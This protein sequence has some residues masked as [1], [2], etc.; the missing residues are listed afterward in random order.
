MRSTVVFLSVLFGTFWTWSQQI[1][2]L[3]EA[4]HDM[5][6]P[7]SIVSMSTNDG[8]PQNQISSLISDDLDN[9]II[10]TANGYCTFNGQS[11][12]TIANND[13]AKWI[14]PQSLYFEKKTRAI[15]CIDNYSNE[16][17][18]SPIIRLISKKKFQASLFQN[19]YTYSITPDGKIYKS[20]IG[21]GNL[22]FITNAPKS[23]GYISL[24]LLNNELIVGTQNKTYIYSKGIWKTLINDCI[25]KAKYNKYSKK[26]YAISRKKAYVKSGDNLHELD[27]ENKNSNA[28]LT[29]IEF[30]K[31]DE[32]FVSSDKGLFYLLSD[33]CDYLNSDYG[34]PSQVFY[35]LFY[36]ENENTLF[37][38][39]ADRGL[40]QLKI[41][42]CSTLLNTDGLG[43]S[44]L[45]SIIK[46][47]NN[48]IICAGTVSTIYQQ[49]WTDLKPYYIEKSSFSC[50]AN[51]DDQVWA[52]T[53]GNGLTQLKNGKKIGQITREKLASGIIHAIFQDT[54]KRIW[55][56]T[57]QGVSLIQN[58]KII[59]NFKPELEFG[60]VIFFKERKNGDI[61]IGG[62]KG[63]S[64]L[65]KDNNRILHLGE[66]NGI[67]AKEVRSVYEIAN[68]EL[69]IGTYGGG[70]YYYNKGKIISVNA[71]EN[72]HLNIDA[73]TLAPDKKGN[74]YISSNHGLY[75][76][77]LKKLIDFSNGKRDYLIPFVLG[78]MDGLL[79][80][81]FNGGF[82]NNYLA[83]S[84]GHFYFPSI[85][86]LVVINFEI[87]K[88]RKLKPQLEEVYIND[89]LVSTNEH[90][91]DR[92]THTVMLKYHCTN[93]S[94]FYNLRYQYKLEGQDIKQ[95]WSALELNG[96]VSFKL[97]PP[98]RYKVYIRGV[99]GFNDNNPSYI[100]YEFT[101]QKYFFEEL[102]FKIIIIALMFFFVFLIF[103]YRTQSNKR[104]E[105]K[106]IEIRNSMNELKI[107][108]IQSKM[109]PHF[110]FNCLNNIQN[111]IVLGKS[112]E[113]QT[114]MSDFSIL[115]R[116]FL[117]Q[118]EYTFIPLKEE[119]EVLK[120]YLRVEKFRFEQEVNV[121]IEVPNALGLYYIPTLL[122]QPTVENA[123]IHGLNHKKG[124]KSLS[125][126]AYVQNNMLCIDI[127]DNGIGREA[128]R[129]LNSIR[130]GHVSHGGKIIQDK[131]DLLHERYGYS[132]IFETIDKP[133]G[134]G[135]IVKFKVPILTEDVTKN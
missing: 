15:Y 118:S 120:S 30:S 33:Y 61:I 65:D 124:E 89:K 59:R 115:L 22:D 81:E 92:N 80:S 20:K 74:L 100:T 127:E 78:E 97:L 10:G 88:F 133:N 4:S 56:G 75:I 31:N 36:N 72:C 68:N 104:K 18:I 114:A 42:E 119:I 103:Y 17:I 50:L 70:I 85:Q 58:N 71:L 44:S 57:Q 52:G 6:C 2:K 48:E 11:F 9:L 49:N 134:S 25:I 93:Y 82:Q 130:K 101:I 95:G 129:N 35:T 116:K 24:G 131:I 86:G 112:E 37:V 91:F 7:F 111:L 83:T 87:P 54:K 23:D 53:W 46:T 125:I 128:S 132:I 45:C 76:V 26:Y 38:G 16:Y 66:K 122:I 135:T 106:E 8:I 21:T 40:L 105:L 79:N 32:I 117:Q 13:K 62:E 84:Q 5:M 27:L 77:N 96:H 39:T 98:G 123:I 41:K 126:K 64:I 43:Q 94:S 67:R 69:L 121:T 47:P 51:V 109:N 110:V 102:A 19:G 113:A 14:L 63:L 73:F 60:N 28:T 90:V 108:A 55:I 107:N 12:R 29:D 99:D 34:L 1:G 3:I